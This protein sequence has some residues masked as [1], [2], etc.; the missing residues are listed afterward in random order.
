MRLSVPVYVPSQ[1]PGRLMALLAPALLC[2]A[3][4][5]GT[6]YQ[7]ILYSLPLEIMQFF[8]PALVG[9]GFGLLCA[10]VIEHGPCRNPLFGRAL[11]VAAVLVM[12]ATSWATALLLDAQAASP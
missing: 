7:R 8:F 1:R 12:W 4:L 11:V 6:M 10:G 2:G 3:V 5:I 9:L